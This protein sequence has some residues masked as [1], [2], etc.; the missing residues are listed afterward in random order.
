M[1]RILLSHIPPVGSTALADDSESRHLLKVRRSKEGEEIEVLDGKGGLARGLLQ[2]EGKQ[3]K[4]RILEV[5]DAQRE[6]PLRLTLGLAVP[7]QLSVFD[8]ALPSLVQLGVDAVFLAP[9]EYGGRL[10]K[11][12]DRY[13]ERL[14]TICIQSLKQCGRTRVP[15][16]RFLEDWQALCSVMMEENDR[17]VLFHPTRDAASD[18]VPKSL[19]LMIGPEGGFSQAE[20]DLA[21]TM[22]VQ[23]QGL[24]PRIL[25]METAMVGACF[26]AQSLFGDLI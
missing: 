9:T 19:G 15:E 26:W 7:S 2:V 3:A 14:Q 8:Q 20:V 11:G 25:K 1:K 18:A 6:S 22:G 21:R 24:G 17:V 16:I 10:K 4:V 5:L 12:G 13:R 23:V